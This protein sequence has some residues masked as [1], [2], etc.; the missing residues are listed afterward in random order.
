LDEPVVSLKFGE[1][2]ELDLRAYELR[3]RGRAVRLPRIPMQILIFL[4]ERRPDLVTREQIAD[5]VWGRGV[6][7]ESDNSING[8]IRKI[9][10][11]LKDDADHPRYIRTITGMGY[12]FIAEVSAI[13]GDRSGMDGRSAARREVGRLTDAAPSAA[14]L[15]VVRSSALRRWAAVGAA[16]SFLL[17]AGLYLHASHSAPPIPVPADQRMM[18]AVLPFENLTG[19]AGQDYFTDGFTEEMITRLG[20]FAP[21]RLGVIARTSIMFYKN[22]RTPLDKLGRELGVQYV[23]EGSVRRDQEWVRITA[24]LIRVEDQTHVWARE[25]DRRQG[26]VLRVQEE[27]AAAIADQIELSLGQTPPEAR[28]PASL[29]PR[30]YEAYDYYLK[31]RYLWN[32]RTEEGLRLAIESFLKSIDLN[33]NDARAYSGLADAYALLGTYTYVPLAEVCAKARDA[34]LKSL[35]LDPALAAAHTSLALINEQCDWDWATAGERFRKAIDLDP[36]YAT[37]HHW[38]AEYLAFMGRHDEALE[39]MERARRLDPRSLIIATDKGVFLYFARDFDRS[40]EQF[41]SVL[42]I[43]PRFPRANMIV[44]AYAQ[45]GR[46]DEALADLREWQRWDKG[47][48]PEAWA[49]YVRG[50]RGDSSRARQAVQEVE[51]MSQRSDLGPRI[52]AYL[53]TGLKEEALA[54]LQQACKDHSSFLL[55]LQADPVF[56]PLR[57]DRRFPELLRCAGFRR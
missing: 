54:S 24:Q 3:R 39:E 29:S 12:R 21:G 10:L 11:A 17:I 41:R 6:F 44:V 37:A 22:S 50:R 28:T 35:Q 8:A 4:V 40:I 48:W 51:K 27:I 30:D 1:D 19:D 25:Y 18:L 20:S 42:A 45:R 55:N 7:L 16:A 56:D 5:R 9:R 33:G 23:L 47:V 46:F 43:D 26:D 14:V 53:G 57:D 13:E 49:A 52:V 2:F 34:A 32:E 31:G 15:P 38:Y 36:N